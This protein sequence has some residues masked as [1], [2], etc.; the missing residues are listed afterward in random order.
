MNKLKRVGLQIGCAIII[1]VIFIIIALF[2][3]G[4]FTE[5]IIPNDYPNIQPE[6]WTDEF[7][8]IYISASVFC[9]LLNAVVVPLFVVFDR[10]TKVTWFCFA[11]FN[12]LSM[13]AG[14][15]SITMFFPADVYGSFVVF[16]LFIGEY[17]IT[18]LV[19]TYCGPLGFSPLRPTKINGGKRK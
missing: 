6:V 17:L 4:Y 13:M 8:R 2:L 18:F 7:L 5:N 12:L 10:K 19:S 1:P 3:K 14:L 9:I 15:G 16:L 11:I